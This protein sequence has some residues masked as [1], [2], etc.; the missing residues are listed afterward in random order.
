MVEDAESLQMVQKLQEKPPAQAPNA[1][2]S[3]LRTKVERS[4]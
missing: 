4:H 2:K 3:V 1:E